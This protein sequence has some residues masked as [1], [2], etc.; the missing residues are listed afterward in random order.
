MTSFLTCYIS[1]PPLSWDYFLS[2]YEFQFDSTDFLGGKN[3]CCG[4]VAVWCFFVKSVQLCKL[5]LT[6]IFL[7]GE[8]TFWQSLSI[9][10]MEV[11]CL[12]FAEEAATFSTTRQLTTLYLQ[13]FLMVADYWR[14]GGKDCAVTNNSL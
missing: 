5:K 13:L 4:D 14:E 11:F 10:A 9:A 1:Y 3:H 2:V 12:Y 8:Y 7:G 6:Q